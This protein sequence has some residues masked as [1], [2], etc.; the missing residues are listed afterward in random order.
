MITIIGPGRVGQVLRRCADQAAIPVSVLG[1]GEPISGDLLLVC[2]RAD[3]LA[4]VIDATSPQRL[5]LA[6]QRFS[7]ANWNH[8]LSGMPCQ[9]RGAHHGQGRILPS[10][11]AGGP[12]AGGSEASGDAARGESLTSIRLQ[13]ANEVLWLG[14]HST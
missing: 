5:G 3:D 10:R 2:T 7:L 9:N 11:C 4:A 8:T 13:D 6:R 14:D 1:R 12:A